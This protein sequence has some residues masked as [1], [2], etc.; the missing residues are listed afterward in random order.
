M[1]RFLIKKYETLEP[2]TPGEQ[3]KDSVLVK[4]NTNESPYPPAP[5]VAEAVREAAEKLQLYSDPDCT[6]LRSAIAAMT[7]ADPDRII[8]NN[9]SD[10]TLYFAFMAY[11]DADCPAVFPDITYGF[12]PVFAE[13]CGIEYREIP[14]RDDLRIAPEDYYYAGGTV[15]IANPNA[16]T[17]I[18]LSRSEIEDILRHNPDNMVVIDEAYVD[19]GTDTAIPLTERYDNLLVIQ[20]FSKSR[21]LA[22]A[23]LGYG[24]G[25][26]EII[27]DLNALRFSTNPYNVDRLAMAA[28]IATLANDEISISNCKS[29]EATRADTVDKLKKLGFEM[30]D[31]TANFIFIRHPGISGN[32][33]FTELRKR[34]VIIRHFSK[35]RISDYNRVTIGSPEQMEVFLRET[36][37]ILIKRNAI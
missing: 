16:P 5:A 1:S 28:G 14:L 4:L 30:T 37:D 29:V 6:E 31:S 7:G 26:R 20:T 25:S 8:C 35:E 12:Y 2:Y 33:L 19:F 10:E 23:R 3:P 21:S 32:D 15:F 24:I 11:C 17:G 22:G 27:A 18:P 34:G 9:G 36:E 13:I